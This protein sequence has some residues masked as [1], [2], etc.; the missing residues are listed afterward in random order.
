MDKEWSVEERRH[1]LE[2][3]LR[4]PELRGIHDMRT[5]SS[6]PERFVQFHVSVDPDMTVRHA[7]QVMD[8]I[9]DALRQDFPGVEILIHPDP[10]GHD[11]REEGDPLRAA[12][13]RRL[14]DE[15]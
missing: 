12:E 5:R 1:F 14:L 9:E 2:I 6:G 13:S 15:D 4:H 3:A 7:H 8:Q 10:Y 11:G